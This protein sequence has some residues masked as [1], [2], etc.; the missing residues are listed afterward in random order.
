MH[1]FPFT[2]Q[3]WHELSQATLAMTNA[4]LQDDE[5]LRLHHWESVRTILDNLRSKYGNHSVL[6]ETQAD[7]EDSPDVQVMLYRQAIEEATQNNLPTHT[8]RISLAGV[9]IEDFQSFEEANRELEACA[10][11]VRHQDDSSL[12]DDWRELRQICE[13]R[14]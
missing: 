11:A 4:V 14:R 2:Q 9:L 12:Q 10:E 8:I 5:P 3:E 6:T 13:Q 7:F 1:E